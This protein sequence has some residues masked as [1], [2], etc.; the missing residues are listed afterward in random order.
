MQTHR[1]GLQQSNH[2]TGAITATSF[3]EAQS[4]VA[5]TMAPV[6]I[7]TCLIG[8]VC[9]IMYCIVAPWGVKPFKPPRRLKC[10]KW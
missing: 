6:R 7:Y 10:L 4:C 1:C 8:F 9:A 5:Q 2:G 3:S